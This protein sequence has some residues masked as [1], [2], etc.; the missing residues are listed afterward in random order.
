M[1]E[2]SKEAL[3]IAGRHWDTVRYCFTPIKDIALA[4][5][6]LCSE[7]VAAITAERDRLRIAGNKM[8]Y[9]LRTW[10]D[11]LSG[12]QMSDDDFDKDCGLLEWHDARAD[13]ARAVM[14]EEAKG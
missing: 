1:L 5:D 12:V 8:A 10:A 3:E 11:C 13:I 14:G 6:A 7:R 2:P 4:I 9:F